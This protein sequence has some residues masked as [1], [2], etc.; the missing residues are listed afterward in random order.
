MVDS[1]V[2]AEANVLTANVQNGQHPL[3]DALQ[4]KIQMLANGVVRAS[5]R[6]H[7]PLHE[8][9]EVQDVIQPAALDAP[10][11]AEWTVG[12]NGARGKV[13]GVVATISYAPLVVTVSVDGHEVVRLNSKDLLMLEPYREKNPRPDGEHAEE[14]DEQEEGEGGDAEEQ[15]REV[16]VDPASLKYPYDSDGMWEEKFDGHTDT[17]KRG[18]A[19]VALDVAFVDVQHVYGIPEH[20]TDFVLRST[21]SEGDK[22]YSEPYRLWNLDV[23]EYDLDVPMSLYG[24]VPFLIGH[25]ARTTTG[26]LWLNAAE[27]YVDIED[28][29]DATTGKA[30]KSSHWISESGV[31]DVYVV[32]GPTPED[33]YRQYAEL[34]G[35]AAL[36]QQF[37]TAY[38]QCRWNYKN[39]DDVAAVDAGFDEHDIPYDVLWLDIEHTDDKKYFTWDKTA[40]PTPELMQEAVAAKGRKMVTII[41]PH[42][43]RDKNYHVHTEAESKGLYV[44]NKDSATY[45]GWCWPGSSSY[46]DFFAPHVRE[47]WA[48]QFKFD[49]YIGSTPDLFTWNDMN[50]PSVFNGPEVTMPKDNLHMDVV[51]HRDVHNMYGFYHQWATAEGQLVREEHRERPFV[52]T[53]SFFAGSQRYGAVWTG[54]N[55]AQWSH[56]EAAAPMLL[57]LSC[58]GISFCGADVGGFFGD[59]DAEL[60]TR[61]YQAAAFQPFFRGHAHIDTKR[62][63]PWLF[64]EPHTTRIRD[65]IRQ[66]Y[67]ILPYVY[68]TFWQSSV[69]GLPVMRPLWLHFA[70]DEKTFGVESQ[71]MLGDALMVVPVVASGVSSMSVYMPGNVPW[72]HLASHSR[73]E[74][75]STVNVSCAI[76]EGVPVFQRGGTIVARRERARRS[77][78]AMTQDPYTLTVAMDYNNEASGMLYADDGHS[79]GYQ[80]GAFV[81]RTFEFAN[82]VLSSSSSHNPVSFSDTTTVER[83]VIHGLAGSF[84]SA[85]LTHGD[86]VSLRQVVLNHFPMRLV[87][88]HQTH[89]LS[90][91]LLCCA[92]P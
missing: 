3:Q 92:L 68:T 35:F 43:K 27:T 50:E 87:L 51:E 64:G 73:H 15:A 28:S 69:T 55:M 26:V 52:L 83:V 63:E 89:S 78:R 40:F 76:D 38:H 12:D 34:T 32:T 36:P 17:K 90:H 61:W 77:S 19:A 58:A 30:S 48:E 67:A 22:A 39:E 2:K 5:V 46:L 79:F 24:A 59:P 70:A 85:V 71:F 82:N 31:V 18:P 14:A 44:K 1:S 25:N 21:R 7:S 8:R 88:L 74:G 60:L 4:L 11:A 9:W 75:R 65:A 54:D 33:M 20:A 62:R 49:K 10:A 6:E 66:R 37:A 86:V 23:F 72:Y 80:N 13:G 16:E 29:V 42:I 56:L 53:R 47:Y 84:S 91:C 57:S 81:H 45:E 41:D